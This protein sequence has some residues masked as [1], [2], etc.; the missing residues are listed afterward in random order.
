MNQFK[1]KD[2]CFSG[3]VRRLG[4]YALEGETFELQVLREECLA[5]HVGNEQS[6]C[7]NSNEKAACIDAKR[8]CLDASLSQ[9]TGLC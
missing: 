3:L 8:K 1:A 5:I 7:S 6:E 9:R 4:W 2:L